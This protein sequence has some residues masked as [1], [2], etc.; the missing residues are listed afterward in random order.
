MQ[1]CI[2]NCSDELI[3]HFLAEGHTLSDETY[4]DAVIYDNCGIGEINASNNA[5]GIFLINACGKSGEEIDII[6][7]N[8]LYSPI[9]FE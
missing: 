7:K 6:L 9:F 8:R 1:I 2:K 4:A 5:N 3:R